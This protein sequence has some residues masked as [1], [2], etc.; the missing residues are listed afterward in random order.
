[1]CLV[2]GDHESIISSLCAL[3]F[4]LSGAVSKKYVQLPG[5][6]HEEDEEALQ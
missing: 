6:D 1:M 2:G 4:H 5:S 3:S